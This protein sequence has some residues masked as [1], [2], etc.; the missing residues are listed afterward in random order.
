MERD[1]E[2][3]KNKLLLKL[4][5]FRKPLLIS[6]DL[7][8]T[9]FAWWLSWNLIL[10][11]GQD[12]WLF[13][14]ISL[15]ALPFSYGVQLLIY[16]YAGLYRALLTYASFRFAITILKAVSL[17]SLLTSVG[18]KLLFPDLPWQLFL[19]NWLFTLTFTGFARY[20]PRFYIEL[21]QKE[22]GSERR[23]LIYGAGDVGDAVA[24][25][26]LKDKAGMYRIIGFIDDNKRKIGFKVH[27]LPILGGGEKLEALIKTHKIDEIII[28]MSNY[29]ADSLRSLH[30]PPDR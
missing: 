29:P 13:A 14:K 25:S 8:T 16:K 4:I 10:I 15:V 30:P 3:L 26:I 5:P 17:T 12:Y 23:V 24:R 18:I 21:G 27:N 20:F 6:I 28:S 7:I 2:T 1:S 9:A 11:P 19:I 22:N